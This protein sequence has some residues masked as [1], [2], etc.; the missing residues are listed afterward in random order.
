MTNN[1]VGL[2]T[3]ILLGIFII[4][5]AF[6]SMLVS[7]RKKIEDFSIG[8]AFG[9]ITTLIITDLI[10]E[11]FEIYGFSKCYIFIIFILLGFF[12]LKILDNFVP[13]HHEHNHMNKKEEH[14]NLTHIGL[15]TTLAI[16]IHNLIEGIA[17]Y[18]SALSS[19]NLAI[20]LALG[21]GFHNIPLG[22]VIASSIY[23][24]EK[25]KKKTIISIILVALSTF[26]GG[27]FMYLFNLQEISE[28]ILGIFLS[29]TIGMLSFII[30]DELIPRIKDMKVKKTTIIGIITGFII[31][32][33]AYII[34]K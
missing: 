29:L 8:L 17:V 21:V 11:V 16:I 14:E 7:K 31:L 5:G 2:L 27:L 22:M 12:L 3:T 28:S 19:T 33:I 24:N 18:S 25:D 15:I 9:V 1:Q 30:I 20:T 34:G 32:I 23:H 10:P 4:I 26:I 6:I 13:D